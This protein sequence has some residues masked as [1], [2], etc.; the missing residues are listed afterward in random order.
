MRRRYEAGKVGAGTTLGV[1][2]TGS[3]LRVTGAA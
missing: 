2:T 3:P 1:R